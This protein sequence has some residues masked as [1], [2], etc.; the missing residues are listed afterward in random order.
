MRTLSLLLGAG[1]LIGFAGGCFITNTA[2]CGYHQNG[3]DN[4]CPAGFVCNVCAADNN[5]CVPEGEAD[6]I[7][8]QC[9]DS[10]TIGTSTEPGTIGPTDG[11]STVPTGTDTT[12]TTTDSTTVGVTT[13]GPTSTTET[14]TET[15]T[16]T[17]TTEAPE[18][19]IETMC[20][21]MNL[22]DPNCGEQYC[23]A[24][25]QCGW[26]T[27]LPQDKTCADVD[28]ATPACDEV[29]GKCVECTKDVAQLCTGNTPV[30]DEETHECAPCTEHSQCGTTAC[31]IFDGSCFP[32]TEGSVFYVQGGKIDCQAKTG[33]TEN[34]P[35]CKLTDVPLN[36]AKVTIRLIAS[37]TPPGGL[38][39]PENSV[40][41]IVKH[42]ATVP[43]INGQDILG[44]PVSLGLNS[45]LYLS[46]VKLRFGQ[47]SLV[48]CAGGSL[49]A[50]DAIWEGNGINS[51]R[52]I[53]ASSCKVSVHRSKILRCGAAMQV[54]N[55]DVR[56]ENSFILENGAP[57]AQHPA[58]NFLTNAKAHITYSTIALNRVVNTVSTFNCV[59]NG[60]DIVLRNSAVVGVTKLT[61]CNDMDERLTFEN[62]RFEEVPDGAMADSLM[63][64]WFNAPVQDVYTPKDSDNVMDPLEDT[65]MW[66]EGD[67]RFDFTGLT[68]I[69]TEEPSFAG[70]RQP[71]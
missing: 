9:R 39:V 10:G 24:A 1:A 28:A 65:A 59:G 21:P 54:A 31:D 62:G 55:S 47:G 27:S 51:A 67:P 33:L 12:E 60:Q 8:P 25:G 13:M 56:I 64:Q 61:N 4:P 57:T 2:H 52:A 50:H 19:T 23:V 46:G 69:P 35:F 63:S 71:L 42:K 7:E 34:D 53:D 18:T 29:S 16:D 43:E 11:P 49:W 22:N 37:T 20:D 41:A 40:V 45:R 66:G 17:S 48:K 38:A 14:T 3:A 6:S 5:G 30:C 68:P 36:A 58:F 26:C 32:D 15:T 44:T 70:A